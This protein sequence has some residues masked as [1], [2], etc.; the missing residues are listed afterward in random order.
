[1]ELNPVEHNMRRRTDQGEPAPQESEAPTS[2]NLQQ[3]V[4]GLEAEQ[5][6]ELERKV[7][8]DSRTYFEETER[9]VEAATGDIVALYNTESSALNPT[10]VADVLRKEGMDETSAA[11]AGDVVAQIAKRAESADDFLEALAEHYDPVKRLD[12]TLQHFRDRS[13]NSW[14]FGTE[15]GRERLANLLENLG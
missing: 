13:P 11:E 4:E 15:V 12:L 14:Y 7:S 5:T 10:S 1:M 3:Q 8:E 6:A 9:Q 2:E